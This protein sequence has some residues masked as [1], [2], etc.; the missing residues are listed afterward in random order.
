MKTLLRRPAGTPGDDTDLV[1]S[2]TERADGDLHPRHTA[3][4]TLARRQRA[5]IGWPWV[6]TD[7]VHGV[8]VH[9]VD[10][11]DSADEAVAV[12]RDA[13]ADVITAAGAEVPLAVWAADCAPVV[14]LGRRGRVVLVH[15]GWRG[16]AAGVV[17][18][19]VEQFAHS[20]DEVASAV[21]GPV[22]H[23]CCYGFGAADLEHVA[24][25]VGVA[26]DVVSATT[27]NGEPALDVPAAV[28]AALGRHGVELDAAGA[29]T[30]CAGHW[31]SHRRGESERHALVV[32]LDRAGGDDGR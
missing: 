15:A 3:Q 32:W 29:C 13:R 8:A 27:A 14:L 12:A 19:A 30:G 1:V 24:D 31:F 6:M 26:P 4:S 28:A 22:I 23:P 18:V 11:S 21:L 5:L 2:S 16:L 25:G 7:Q 20:D 17:D 10:P 9:A